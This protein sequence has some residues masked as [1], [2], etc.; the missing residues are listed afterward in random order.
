LVRSGEIS[1]VVGGPLE[2]MLTGPAWLDDLGRISDWSASK[3]EQQM[4]AQQKTQSLERKEVEAK[5]KD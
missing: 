1:D 5:S 4:P 2:A 3:E